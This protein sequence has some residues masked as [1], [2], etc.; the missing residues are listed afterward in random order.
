MKESCDLFI[1]KLVA[2]VAPM[3]VKLEEV[4]VTW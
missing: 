1:N 4:L 3:K 2:P